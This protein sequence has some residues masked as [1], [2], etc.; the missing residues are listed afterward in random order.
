MHRIVVAAIAATATLLALAWGCGGDDYFEEYDARSSGSATSGEAGA[1]VAEMVTVDPA[2]A[3]TV[4]GVV[5]FSGDAPRFPP[6]NMS[7]EP[8]CVR[9]H[10][11]RVPSDRV[12]VNDGK[13]QHVLVWVSGGLEGKRFPVRTDAV[14][15][16]Q[17]GCIYK[18][19][20]VAVQ[21]GQAINITN[22]DPT[23]HNVHPLPREN[24]EWNKSQTS[25]APA[26]EYAFPRAEMKIAVKCNI[27][28][29]MQAYIHVM[30]HPYFAVSGADGAFEI[31][32]LP[33]G[34]YTLQAVHEQFGEQ[35]TQITIGASE[36]QE[37]AFAFAR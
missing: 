34:T 17:D 6:V 15:L 23:T 35:E 1:P 28:P 5:T 32:N 10:G 11:G 24:R 19:H 3:V 8:D 12:V 9:L 29:W 21:M 16:D 36:T 31:G 18:P 22:S 4:K 25:G 37:V 20:V 30:E 13:L 33:P 26:I 14:N 2:T 27:H 7:A